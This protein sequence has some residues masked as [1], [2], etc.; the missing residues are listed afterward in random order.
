MADDLPEEFCALCENCGGTGAHFDTPQYRPGGYE[1]HS[2]RCGA[3]DGAG[4]TFT[5]EGERMRRFVKA[6]SSYPMPRQRF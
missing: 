2:G 5:A 3:C 4:L 1:M 6:L